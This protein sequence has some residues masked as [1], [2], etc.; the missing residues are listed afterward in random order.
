MILFYLLKTYTTNEE[1]YSKFEE[2][3]RKL[4]DNFTKLNTNYSS[5]LIII[6]LIESKLNDFIKNNSNTNDNGYFTFD[7]DLELV[8]FDKKVELKNEINKLIDKKFELFFKKLIDNLILI[9]K[10]NHEY[11]KNILVEINEDFQKEIICSIKEE[12]NEKNNYLKY[13]NRTCIKS[14]FYNKKCKL[15]CGCEN[16][17]EC[18]LKLCNKIMNFY[19]N[20]PEFDAIKSLYNKNNIKFLRKNNL[21]SQSNKLQYLMELIGLF[22]NNRCKK[23]KVCFSIQENYKLKIL[24]NLKKYF[25]EFEIKDDFDK[26]II[27]IPTDKFDPQEILNKKNKTYNEY[28]NNKTSKSSSTSKLCIKSERL[29]PSPSS[30]ILL[31]VM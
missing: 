7:K 11:F 24:F 18:L 8:Y 29:L 6:Q 3:I 2:H 12:L 13:D 17:R 15:C 4:D 5:L 10:E 31:H 26:N 19:E 28:F 21:K 25:Q 30:D 16:K 20:N 27:K 9:M 22:G 1:L 14:T 23:C